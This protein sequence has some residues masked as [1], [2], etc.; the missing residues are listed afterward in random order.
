MK[1]IKLKLIMYYEDHPLEA[2][3]IYDGT[4]MTDK[5]VIFHK[6]GCYSVD[7]SHCKTIKE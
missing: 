3:K 4:E 5:Y 6:T 7:K 1:T 2:G